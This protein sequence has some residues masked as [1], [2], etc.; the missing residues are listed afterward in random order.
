[1]QKKLLQAIFNR[2]K[3]KPFTVT[4]W[5][6][7]VEKY[8]AEYDLEP[9]FNLQIK[10]KLNLSQMLSDPELKF[11]EAYMDQKIEC[12][13]D[14]RDVFE[15]L[16]ENERLFKNSKN[17]NNLLKHFMRRQKDATKQEQVENVQYH[18]DLGNDFFELWLDQTMSYSCAYFKTQQDTLAE[19]QLQKIDHILAKLQ[20]KKGE[21]LLD[22]GSGWGW[23][24]IKAAKEYG[25][26]AVGITLS[27]E[28][29]IAT[30][31][32][33]QEEGLV[34]Q[35][36]VE[37]IDYRDLADAQYQFDKVV[38]VGMFEHVGKENLAEYFKAVHNMIKPG[39]LSLLH[40]ITRPTEAPTNPWLEKYIFPWGYIPSLREALW[41]LSE[42]SFHII[43]VESLRLHYAMTT[44][45]WARNFEAVADKV[46][47]KYGERFVRMWR[48]YLVG[49]TMSFR[50]SGLDI[51]Q[52]LFSK[53][54][55]NELPLTRDYLYQ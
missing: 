45:R 43:D 12:K 19:A 23:L 32:R 49:C 31:R 47:E 10:D 27:K 44:D 13:G 38:S 16:L 4:Y 55:N 5:D 7:T 33:I 29:M 34:G 30:R 6:G 9:V 46:A 20:L 1:M 48:L 18:Y 52:I 51:H 14:L 41:E 35:V 8:C 17:G 26:D 53:G 11:G 36:K 37:L 42:H 40:T 28:Q 15:L 54:L 3:G 2:I 25:A 21:K 50:Y 39:G 22:I 24:V